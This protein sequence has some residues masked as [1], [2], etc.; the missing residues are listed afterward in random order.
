M[1]EGGAFAPELVC[2]DPLLQPGAV[3][4]SSVEVDEADSPPR[5][6]VTLV[7]EDAVARAPWLL[8]RRSYALTGGA[9]L[10][11]HVV[12]V[13][14]TDRVDRV[15]VVLDAVGDFS[16]Y[17]LSLLGTGADPFY[18][19]Y[20][21]RFRLACEDPFDCRRPTEQAPPPPEED[22]AID[23]LAKDYASF[24]QALL[25]FLAARFPVWTERS[26]AD[27][28]IALLELL[29][30]TGDSLSYLQDAVANEAFVRTARQ[31][32]SVQNH[33]GLLG[34]ELDEG[35]S[36]HA[37]LQFRVAQQH[38]LPAGFA[39][40]TVSPAREGAVV[41]ET[42]APR[43]LFPE[44][45]E[46][47][48]YDWGNPECCLPRTAT[49]ATL[50][51]SVTSLLAGDHLVLAD[52][53]S[54]VRDVV[55]LVAAPH[56][57]PADPASASEAPPLTVVR[58][59]PRTPL[60]HDY[61]A[62]TT[63]VGGNVVLATHGRTVSEE[64]AVE[65]GRQVAE[66]EEAFVAPHTGPAGT[67]FFVSA[68]GFAPGE[69]V[70]LTIRA[71]DETFSRRTL[72]AGAAG[73]IRDEPVPIPAT[74]PAGAWS[75]TFAGADPA[76]RPFARWIVGDEA[77]ARRVRGPRLRVGLGE[78]PLAHVDTWV[79]DLE[80]PLGARTDGE[81]A[82]ARRSTPQV[83][84][85]VDGRRWRLLPTLLESGP[86]D[87]VFRVE[88]DNDGYATLVF[89]RG[90]DDDPGETA[91]GRRPPA[92][93]TILATYRVGGGTAGNVGRDTVTRPD[94][95]KID[96]AWFLAVTNPLA[97]EGGRDPES[98][99]RARLV[100]LP[101]VHERIVA[102]TPD[103]YEEAARDFVDEL[104]R[105][106]VSRSGADFRWT[107]SW[108][109][110]ALAVDPAGTDRLGP[111][112]ARS[113]LA[114]LDRRRLAGYDVQLRPP[115]YVPLEL[116]LRLCVARGF[117]P[118]E[119]ERAVRLALTGTAPAGA[120]PGFFD[121]DNFSFGQPLAVSRLFEAVM[122]VPGVESA[123]VERL[124]PLHDPDPAATTENARREGFLPA[125]SDQILQLADDPNFPERGRLVL[126]TLDGP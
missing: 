77:S 102:V 44:Q 10:H 97:A 80:R 83:G 88:T 125:G 61:C 96:P 50:R 47:L 103:D 32:R 111:E 115:L 56:E 112:L 9:R 41:F 75:V 108:L 27:V 46:L 69:P 16:V 60:R 45:N 23:Y 100:G 38:L 63:A 126:T 48:L 124:A 28:G 43:A 35:A 85:A 120:R 14:A 65:R 114:Y 8:E 33:L 2:P 91:F 84:I 72:A 64:H 73:A 70:E 13:E 58:W 121:P 6:V 90:G 109:T 55:R 39:V 30:A 123:T 51:G 95:D 92:E 101:S 49:S 7:P 98:S 81:L 42:A 71:P 79:E 37:W 78:G 122:A 106:L 99:E 117:A 18:S 104:G 11:P 74:A 110:V 76:H 94:P 31:R 54:G 15:A 1:S 12:G 68:L 3:G 119:V 22:V 53:A 26:E 20:R 113:L 87:E 36:A 19:S 93:S 118:W 24:R 66:A 116:R 105:R 107:G 21:L 34:Y 25:D 59:S 67:T 5:L 82:Y 89:G 40:S 29:A 17:T 57:V 4:I 62:A 86:A 52:R